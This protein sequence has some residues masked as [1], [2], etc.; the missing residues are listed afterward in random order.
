MEKFITVSVYREYEV[1]VSHLDSEFVKI[2]EFVK[3]E[4]LR[5]H[6]QDMVDGILLGDDYNAVIVGG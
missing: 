1:D 6:Q 5:M 2:E 4:A 3:D